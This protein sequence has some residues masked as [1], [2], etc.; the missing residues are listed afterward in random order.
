MKYQLETIPVWEAYEKEGECPVCI[1]EEKTEKHYVD[2]F[3]GNSVMVPEIRVQVNQSGF[4]PHHFALLFSGGNKLGLALMTHTHLTE[5]NKRLEKQLGKLLKAART[6]SSDGLVKGIRGGQSL[7]RSL[8]E[9]SRDY[10]DHNCRCMICE[11][12]SNTLKRYAFT[13]VYLWQKESDFRETLQKSKGFCLPHFY[14]VNEMAAEVLSG[15]QLAAWIGDVV[16]LEQGNLRRLETQV[17][18]FTQK[19][20]YRSDGIP[21]KDARDALPR[22][23]QKLTGKFPRDEQYGLTDRKGPKR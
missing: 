5:L 21:W 23:L 9:S 20:D 13:I 3:L 2:F 17:H 18:H 12:L 22:A 19:F 6:L 1:L 16:P 11:R 8:R 14:F 7:S 15:R 10:S 4:C